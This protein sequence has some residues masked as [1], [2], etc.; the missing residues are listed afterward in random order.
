MRGEFVINVIAGMLMGAILM[1]LPLTYMHD[2]RISKEDL[3]RLGHA[4]MVNDPETGGQK[5][6]LKEVK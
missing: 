5:F 4:E 3:V 2:S 1:I 6:M